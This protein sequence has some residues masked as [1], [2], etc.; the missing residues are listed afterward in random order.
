MKLTDFGI[1]FAIIFICFSTI[2]DA[3]MQIVSQV[4]AEQIKYN[5]AVDSAL[6][7][8]L[9]MLVEADNGKI[10]SVDSDKAVDTFFTSLCINLGMTVSE[11]NKEKIKEYI[12]VI[13]FVLNDG[14]VVYHHEF[15]NYD[16]EVTDSFV[17]SEEKPFIYNDGEY[18]YYFK[19]DNTVTLCTEND[20]F[21]G[22]ADDLGI[23]Y[24]DS[25]LSDSQKYIS[26][27]TQ[28]IID[29]ITNA[30]KEYTSEVYTIH[31]NENWNFYI[32]YEQDDLWNRT[33]N[34][35]SMITVFSGYPYSDSSR[36]YFSKFA[37][38]GARIWK[39]E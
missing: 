19:L 31:G 29:N 37:F 16:N 7:D 5:N 22:Y 24:R 9:F 35:I 10:I 33:I 17:K 15:D 14:F 6:S 27:R 26:I 12:P 30:L 25:I 36:G 32:P 20:Y 18:T 8:A 39:K 13:I 3:K 2:T 21:E 4:A 38:G 28:T 1:I 23:V 34:D 11:N